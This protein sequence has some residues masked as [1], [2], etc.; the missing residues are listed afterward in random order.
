[1]AIGCRTNVQYSPTTEELNMATA[2]RHS[3]WAID[4]FIMPKSSQLVDEIPA[5]LIGS[6]R[7]ENWILMQGLKS[8]YMAVV[9][10]T[11]G[12]L[13]LHTYAA[14]AVLKS[15]ADRDGSAYNDI[16]EIGRGTGG[17]RVCPS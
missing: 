2:A 7:F 9:D 15:R 14:E 16:L 11:E 1:M 4:Y 10:V 12:H 6:T 3:D 17:G 13:V 8:T 5:F